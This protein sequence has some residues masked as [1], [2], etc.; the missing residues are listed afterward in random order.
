MGS[1]FA[2]N[3]ESQPDHFADRFGFAA[4]A[5]ARQR[6][7]QRSIPDEILEWLFQYGEREHRAGDCISFFFSKQSIQD[8]IGDHG[9]EIVSRRLDGYQGVYGVVSLKITA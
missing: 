7:Q 2:F 1:R 6:K 5:H 9:F 8:L 3:T 4:T